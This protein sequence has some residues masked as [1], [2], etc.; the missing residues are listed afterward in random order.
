MK[1]LL[2]TA[3][4]M[5]AL[6]TAGYA[7]GAAAAAEESPLSFDATVDFYSA[8]VWRGLILD[9]HAVMQPGGTV[10]LDLKEAGSL[11]ANVWMNWD[12][13]QKSKHTTSTRTGG[14]INELDAT[15]TYSK[16]VGPVSLAAGH[17]WYTFAGAGWPSDSLS[18]EE[19]F[20]SASYANDV[21]TP[22][23]QANYD[24]NFADGLYVNGGVKKDFTISDQLTAG[25]SATL[26]AGND[27]Y[28]EAYYGDVGIGG[29]NM[30]LVDF[31][32]KVYTS[33]ALT[34]NLSVGATLAFTSVVG[35][36]AGI[37]RGGLQDEIV[38]GGVNLAASF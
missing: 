1:R 38:W 16:D 14:G 20:V 12:L 37:D 17:V 28:N 3:A 22:F 35:G 24:Y 5:A 23:I 15:L 30:R 19:I 10:S 8:Y 7:Q 4:A 31:Q 32:A 26:G 6:A 27:A 2:M 9:K 29:L 11:S 18:T 36:E 21:L 25:A 33:Y 34:D 13:S